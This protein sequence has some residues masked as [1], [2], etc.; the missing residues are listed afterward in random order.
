MLETFATILDD[1][2]SQAVLEAAQR[3]MSGDVKD[4]SLKFAPSLP[5]FSVEARRIAD[6]LP[7]RNLKRLPSPPRP[8]ERYNEPK[9]GERERMG[10]KMS[11]LSHSLTV[12]GGPDRVAAANKAGLEELVALA[13]EWKVPVP[14]EVWRQL[15]NRAA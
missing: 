15:G 11:V 4:Q 8:V 6:L 5:E 3:F 12:K 2:P 13:Q 14:E 9:P 7:Y 10:F 1:V